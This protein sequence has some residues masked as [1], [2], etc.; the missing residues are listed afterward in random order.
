MIQ[1]LKDSI[2]NIV[3]THLLPSPTQQD[4]STQIYIYNI[5]DI[6]F[7]NI[8]QA[9]SGKCYFLYSNQQKFD[10]EKG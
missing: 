6:D 10:K 1:T 5:L 7:E 4:L 2:V 9:W 8:V 3:V